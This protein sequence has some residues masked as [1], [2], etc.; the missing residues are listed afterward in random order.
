[1]KRIAFL[2][3]ML[4]AFSASFAFSQSAGTVAADGAVPATTGPAVGKADFD[5]LL[6]QI[7]AVG[8]FDNADFSGVFTIV[9]ERPGKDQTLSQIRMFR[10]DS[11]EQF[12]ILV[13]KPEADKGTGYLQEGDNLW[14]YD[15]VSRRFNHTSMKEALADSKAQNSDFDMDDTVA[16]YYI[17]HAD[18]GNVGKF[19][20]W[21]LTLKA[22]HSEVAYDKIRIF[23]RK[24]RPLV[25]KQEEMSVNGRIM[26]TTLYPRYTEISTGKYFPSQM[27]ILDEINKGEKS[28]ITMTEL[29]TA[30]LPD[31]IFTKAFLEDAQ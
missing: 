26:R 23:V 17:E 20:V 21:I 28:Q 25:L 30:A 5:A 27:L 16:D 1:M 4:I 18:E 12:L 7:D 2:S 14:M 24:D 8:R 22:R 13:L 31:R 10:R 19:P 6:A 3:F 15:P 11:K 9:T 29:S